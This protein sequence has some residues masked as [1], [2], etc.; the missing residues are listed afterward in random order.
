MDKYGP[1]VSVDF[2]LDFMKRRSEPMFVYYPMAL[3]HR[4]MVPT[5]DSKEWKDPDRRGG[6]PA[7]FR[8]HGRLHG[9]DGRSFDQGID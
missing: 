7:L 2:I 9:Q 3:P 5:P 8:G 1:D 4:P 6:E